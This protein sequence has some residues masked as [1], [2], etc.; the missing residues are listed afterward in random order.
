MKNMKNTKKW[1]NKTGK[2]LQNEKKERA[3]GLN[4]HEKSGV[5]GS[6]FKVL[7]LGFTLPY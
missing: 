6:W 5:H 3:S 1:K 2:T 7:G 4:T